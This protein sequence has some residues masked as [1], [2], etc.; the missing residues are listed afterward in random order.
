VDT[1]ASIQASSQNQSLLGFIYQQDRQTFLKGVNLDQITELQVSQQSIDFLKDT[2]EQLLLTSPGQLRCGDLTARTS[3]Q[4]I[5]SPLYIDWYPRPPVIN[6][7]EKQDEGEY[8]LSWSTDE[9]VDF[10]EIE[11]ADDQG[12][13]RLLKRVK[14]LTQT[15]S[16]ALN[17]P[18]IRLKSIMVCDTPEGQSTEK[19]SLYTQ[20]ITQ[21]GYPF[22]QTQAIAGAR[23]GRDFYT[24]LKVDNA[25][26]I[27]LDLNDSSLSPPCPSDLFQ[28][29]DNGLSAQPLQKLQC[30][31]ALNAL[32]EQGHQSRKV[33][34]FNVANT[35]APFRWSLKLNEQQQIV[36]QTVSQT[37]VGITLEKQLDKWRINLFYEPDFSVNDNDD[38]TLEAGNNLY[39]KSVQ[40]VKPGAENKGISSENKSHLALSLDQDYQQKDEKNYPFFQIELSIN[41]VNVASSHSSDSRCYVASSVFGSYRAPELKPLRWLR[42]QIQQTVVG[43]YLVQWYYESSPRWVQWQQ[44]HP[45]ISK[46]LKLWLKWEIRNLYYLFYF[47]YIKNI[48]HKKV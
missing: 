27:T 8:L 46:P 13:F 21:G 20:E 36:I 42:D 39:F 31:F 10:V 40:W 15:A 44:K 38:I 29:N 25:S 22:W 37:L 28:L 3:N 35:T 16:L 34:E 23:L 24:R 12:E 4:T 18:R 33:F 11:V 9:N 19:V 2:Q 45:I 32:S 14:N 26:T 5:I 47:F 43:R 17:S 30:Q 48:L 7:F 1:Y 41:S 6:Q